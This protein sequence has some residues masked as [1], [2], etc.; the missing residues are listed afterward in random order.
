VYDV[1]SLYAYLEAKLVTPVPSP[2]RTVEPL[3]VPYVPK[4]PGEK[5]S[6]RKFLVEKPERKK[7]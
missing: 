2:K 6:L 4:M 1:Q 3:K 5:F 7:K